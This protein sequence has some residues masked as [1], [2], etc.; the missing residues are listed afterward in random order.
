VNGARSACSCPVQPCSRPCSCP[1]HALFRCLLERA[2]KAV[3]PSRPRAEPRA[4]RKQTP[5]NGAE[6]PALGSPLQRGWF[7][8]D[9][10]FSLR[11][12]RARDFLHRRFRRP[13]RRQAPVRASSTG[14][15][16]EQARDDPPHPPLWQTSVKLEAGVGHRPRGGGCAGVRWRLW[17][18]NKS[19][20]PP[21]FRG[22]HLRRSSYGASSGWSAAAMNLIHSLLA[23]GIRA[24]GVELA[25]NAPDCYR[26]RGST[27]CP[28]CPLAAAA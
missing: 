28:R 26:T 13:E 25:S 9:T 22:R 14:Q 3:C 5:I 18:A 1:V 7:R 17:V 10:G 19:K 2:Q 20:E 24:S 6:E 11:P 21:G 4:Y 27:G 15:H 8:V 16:R 12:G 23:E